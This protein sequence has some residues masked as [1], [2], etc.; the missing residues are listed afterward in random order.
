MSN[1]TFDKLNHKAGKLA[2][3]IFKNKGLLKYCLFRNGRGDLITIEI[4]SPTLL[5]TRIGKTV[6][7]RVYKTEWSLHQIISNAFALVAAEH[8]EELLAYDGWLDQKELDKFMKQGQR[9]YTRFVDSGP[10][11]PSKVAQRT[12]TRHGSS[13][14]VIN[15]IYAPKKPWW[16]LWGS[17][18]ALSKNVYRYPSTQD[19]GKPTDHMYWF[20]LNEINTHFNSKFQKGS[21]K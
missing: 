7:K 18:D 5:K 9:M 21:R 2:R 11:V 3:V 12:N 15:S 20:D 16:K 4:I 1:E 8:H 13:M 14:L 6:K 10:L 19:S 17:S